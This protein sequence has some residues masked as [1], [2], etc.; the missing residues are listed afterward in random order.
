MR[1]RTAI[2]TG[3]VALLLASGGPILGGR[4]VSAQT[5]DTL[6]VGFTADLESL[7]PRFLFNTQS[8]SVMMN[9]YEPLVTYDAQ[10]HLKPDLAESYEILTPTTIRFHLRSGV[11]FSNG[12]PFDAAAVKYT[13][14]SITGPGAR[15]PQRAFL[16]AVDHVNVV[17]PL[18]AD[19]VLKQP[20]ARSTLRTLTY[21]GE[22]MPPKF[23]EQ[24]GD[25]FT[26][27]AGTGPFRLVE[28]RPGERVVLEARPDYW[29]QKPSLRRLVF[30][31]IPE[32]GT[33][34]AALE[35][36]DIAFAYNFPIDQI[37][38]IGSNPNITVLSRPTVRLVY[39]AFRVDRTPLGD[40]RVRRAIALGIDRDAINRTLLDYR[41]RIANTVIAPA[42]FGY[43]KDLKLLPYNPGEARRLLTEAGIHAGT[44][45]SFGSVNGRV[46][47]DLQVGQVVAAYLQ[48][49]GFTVKFDAP[50]FGTFSR[51]TFKADSKYDLYLISWSTNSLEADFTM[52][53]NFHES[54]STRTMYRN[55]E[56]SQLID[57]ARATVDDAKASQLYAQ[58]QE[59]V[60][61]DLP[62]V[63]LYYNPDVVAMSK[64]I[65][66]F[67]LRPD[68]L[69]L[70]TYA[71]L[72]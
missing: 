14:E 31:I 56:V 32:A 18:T 67:S 36:G 2:I 19:L 68:E 59:R 11:K 3:I 61:Q 37:R 35:S 33:R 72:K 57:E 47:Q 66:N 42:V 71:Q 54:Y 8:I 9:V 17:N 41:G 24:M 13:I 64:R 58:I 40:P 55:H 20:A 62:W 10:G 52:T 63:P 28:W 16:A 22:I 29:G 38:R 39:V 25:K 7:D 12:E 65:R 1:S 48:A 4:I 21:W 15:S 70:L 30:R 43:D 34:T 46:V 51:E 45:L 5:G 23:S 6:T 27:A 26:A 44:P 49:L 53:P 50:E 60:M 69:I